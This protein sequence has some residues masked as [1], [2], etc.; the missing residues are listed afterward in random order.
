MKSHELEI[1]EESQ[2]L[3]EV[4]PLTRDKKTDEVEGII[5]EGLYIEHSADAAGKTWEIKL[6]SIGNWPEFKTETCYKKVCTFGVCVK[7]P[8]PCLYTR[9]STKSFYARIVLNEDVPG[10]FED[11]LKECSKGAVAVA[12]PLV[13]AGQIPAA[14]AAFFESLKV[15]LIAK[16]FQIASKIHVGIYSKKETGPWHRV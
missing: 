8:Y 14:I 5:A 12:I 4:K 13:I 9:N 11:A 3:E 7:V 1:I 15:C 2:E 16:G 6:V 10:G